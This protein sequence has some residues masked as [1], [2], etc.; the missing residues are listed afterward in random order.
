MLLRTCGAERCANPRSLSRRDWRCACLETGAVALLIGYKANAIPMQHFRHQLT[1]PS[2]DL[3]RLQ[4]PAQAELLALESRP[5]W[6]GDAASKAGITRDCST[7]LRLSRCGSGPG[8]YVAAVQ[9][10][11]VG[12]HSVFRARTAPS[13]DRPV[14]GEPQRPRP[15][16]SRGTA[17]RSLRRVAV[18]SP[19]DRRST[20][21]LHRRRRRPGRHA[22]LG[23]ENPAKPIHPRDLPLL[24]IVEPNRSRP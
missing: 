22:W 11:V 6:G 20:L 13:A 8:K 21:A 4:G 12:P 3:H 18:E 7:P 17:G 16:G 15:A 23:T 24:K 14:R 9:A 10:D 19:P 5:A 1:P 2:T